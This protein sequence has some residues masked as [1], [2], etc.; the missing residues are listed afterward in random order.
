MTYKDY[1]KVVVILGGE[2]EEYNRVK[3]T[4][5]QNFL[6]SYRNEENIDFRI[7]S[8]SKEEFEETEK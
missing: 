3:K 5:I 8:L 4:E 1:W 6:N 7:E 2:E